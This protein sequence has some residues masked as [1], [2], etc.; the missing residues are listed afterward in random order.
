M[1]LFGVWS[2]RV[3]TEAEPSP[4]KN[5]AACVV[6]VIVNEIAH[7]PSLDLTS[8]VLWCLFMNVCLSVHFGISK[9]TCMYFAT[10]S[11]HVTCGR[12]LVILWWQCN[13]VCSFRFVDNVTFSHNRAS[14]YIRLGK[15]FTATRQVAPGMKSAVSN[16]LVTRCYHWKLVVWFGSC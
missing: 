1:I 14:R 12:G 8:H 6:R 7:L 5:M 2:C 4:L 3:P 15:L 13:T 16:C 9:M 10:F 11:V